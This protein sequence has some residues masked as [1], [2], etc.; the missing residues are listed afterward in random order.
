MNTQVNT[1]TTAKVTKGRTV[2][3][4]AVTVSMGTEWFNTYLEQWPDRAGKKPT[5]AMFKAALVL[6][7]PGVGKRPGAESG[8][9]AMCLRPEGC[10]VQQFLLTGMATGPANN[11]RRDLRRVYGL[12]TE[13]VTG[14]PFAFHLRL[15][16]KGRDMLKAA[17]VP[18]GDL[19]L[20]PAI[21]VAKP[22]KATSEPAKPAQ[23]TAQ[24]TA[25]VDT[26]KVD[27]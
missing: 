9:I 18:L 19:T 11:W 15:T 25:P 26:A 14:K 22:A 2:K 7:K 4:A 23:G 8:H 17:G 1:D 20:D 27:A 12:V 3:P 6:G 10:T 21:K 24:V 5:Q 16:A 13:S